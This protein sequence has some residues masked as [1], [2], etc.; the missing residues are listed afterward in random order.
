[1]RIFFSVLT[2]VLASALSGVSVADE[3][4]APPAQAH[5][6]PAACFAHPENW[7]YDRAKMTLAAPGEKFFA[8]LQ[9]C[10]PTFAASVVEAIRYQIQK[11]E[12]DKFM[13]QKQFL[14]AAY[15]ICWA[16]VALAAVALWLRQR[17]LAR[18]LADLEARLKLAGAEGSS[19]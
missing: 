12:T 1:M 8:D 6:P 18:E 7:S 5:V 4:G 15:G 16:I 14:L 19:T 10:D 13:H 3:G 9:K 11:D 17:R 2:L